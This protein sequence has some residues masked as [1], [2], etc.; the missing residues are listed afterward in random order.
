MKTTK[1]LRSIL[2]CV[3][4]SFAASCTEE[5]NEP[6]VGGTVRDENGP[7]TLELADITATTALFKGSVNLNLYSKYDEVGI[8]YSLS[9]DLEIKPLVTN[10]VS[11]TNID[12]NNCF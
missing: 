12:K 10:V 7:I 3:L 4:L 8:I 9:E 2:T 1:L 5:E 6:P 11:I